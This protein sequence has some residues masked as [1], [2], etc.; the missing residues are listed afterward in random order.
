MKKF[1]LSVLVMVFFSFIAENL[2]GIRH[3]YAETTKTELINKNDLKLDYDYEVEADAT[4]WRISFKRQSVDEKFDQRLK[5]KVTDEKDKTIDYPVVHNMQQKDE[6]LVEENFS[7]AMEGQVVLKLPK[8]VDKLRLYVQLDQKKVEDSEIQEDILANKKPFELTVK[9]KQEE[10]SK[11]TSETAKKTVKKKDKT[12]SISSEEF[13]GPKTQSQLAQTQNQSVTTQGT[14]RATTAQ[15]YVNKEPQYTTDDKGT[16]PTASWQPTGQTNV[17]NHQGGVDNVDPNVWDGQQ[18]WNVSPDN[19]TNSYIHYGVG[20][21]REDIALRKYATET[22]KEDE[23]NIRLNVRGDSITKPGVDIFFVLDNSASMEFTTTRDLIN[24]KL[25]KVV[26]VESLKKLITRFKA[27]VPDG[28]DYMRIGGVVFGSNTGPVYDLSNRQQDWDNMVTGYENASTD[29]NM[30]YTQGGLIEAQKKL[31]NSGNDRRKIVFL[32]T[33]GAPNYS[34]TPSLAKEDPE[35]Y[36]DPIRV[37]KYKEDTSQG[38]LGSYN[39]VFL[40]NSQDQA[41]PFSVPKEGGGNPLKIRSHLVIANSQAADL[42]DMGLEIQ[43]IAI[44]IYRGDNEP[45]SKEQL[46]TGLYRMATKKAGASG[47]SAEDHYFYHAENESDFDEYFNSWYDSVLSTAEDGVIED[48]LGDM[49]E[50]IGTPTV[51][52]VSLLNGVG[53]KEIRV[54]KMAKVDASNSRKV[55]ITDIN[56]Y[57]KQEIEVNYKVRLKTTDPSFSLGKWYPANGQT[58]LTPTPNRSEDILDFGVPSVRLKKEDFV[59]PV[60]KRW[61]DLMNF[62]G[63]RGNSITVVLERKNGNTFEKVEEKE[64]KGEDGWKASFAPVEGG[65]AIYRIREIVR[66]PGYAPAT[67][68]HEEFTQ[69]SLGG[70][71][72]LLTNRL[73]KGEISFHKYKEDGQTTFTGTDKPKFTVKRKQDGQVLAKDLEPN[74]SGVVTISGIPMGE[75]VLEETY[76]PTGYVEGKTWDL[77]ATEL[78]NGSGVSVTIDGQSSNIKIINER[79]KDF[80]IPV[81]KYWIDT[82]K[83]EDD[84]WGL[85]KTVQVTLQI[86]DGQSWRDIETLSLTK[87]KDW[88]GKFQGVDGG[89]DKVYRVVE[90]TKIPGYAPPEYNVDEFTKSHLGTN[91]VVVI[92][93]LLEGSTSFTKVRGNSDGSTT[94]FT[95]DDLPKFTVKRKSDGKLLAE[96]LT[97]DSSGKVLLSNIPIGDFIIEESHVPNGYSKLQDIALKVVENAN[98]SL[99]MTFNNESTGE[100]INYLKPF[101]LIISK[102]D[103]D[104]NALRDAKFK[105]TGPNGYDKTIGSTS[106]DGATFIFD[107]LYPGE[108]EVTE[109]VTPTDYEGLKTPFKFTVGE[110]GKV[111]FSEDSNVKG[112][113]TLDDSG[114][115]FGLNSIHLTVKN[116]KKNRAGVLPFTG[117]ITSK[118]FFK[119][120]SGFITVGGLLTGLYWFYSRRK[121]L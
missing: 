106:S 23:F 36:Y 47:N 48:P 18:N 85:R 81:Q 72:V 118:F 57:E 64:L 40:A 70:N 67:K 51:K 96:N 45:H 46:L 8:S 113:Y 97:P 98:G 19:Y 77:K 20:Q 115:N 28:S 35:I 2:I 74:A 65:S 102:V 111:T 3:V 31:Q 11:Q 16:Y 33:D 101:T 100:A 88:K 44:G 121:E 41:I 25:R 92:N 22:D 80:V 117:G 5:L 103:Q 17:I 7:Q 87:D 52:D 32:L 37:T 21:V 109:V 62:W 71:T 12:V 50:L 95:G 54:D 55:R 42:R 26:A 15:K 27:D 39:Y 43:S 30:T 34:L 99:S 14:T 91:D 104:D 110:D 69:T 61:D 76:V 10:S 120:A 107:F 78:A 60:E 116:K 63:H 56:L 93:T 59:I 73:L 112:K 90:K 105:L 66:V 119:L 13:V 29:Q 82:Y 4:L 86:K 49:V 94:P 83:N 108:Y 24:G 84:Y 58:T 75:Y 79:K 114:Q 38:T 6:W 68:S 1:I 89:A 53:A 9:P